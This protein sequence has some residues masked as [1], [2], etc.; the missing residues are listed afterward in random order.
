MAAP[1]RGMTTPWRFARL[2]AVG[3]VGEL[4]GINLLEQEIGQ[5]DAHFF[6][7]HDS[8]HVQKRIDSLVAFLVGALLEVPDD[9]PGCDRGDDSA[10][11]DDTANVDGRECTMSVVVIA[12][13]SAG[14][15]FWSH[16]DK[17][18]AQSSCL[19]VHEERWNV[20]LTTR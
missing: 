12:C 16:L 8:L 6:F 19:D 7:S 14:E 15:K 20:V 1:F 3:W 9:E 10:C 17:L 13:S 4:P 2:N 18:R 11:K 5:K